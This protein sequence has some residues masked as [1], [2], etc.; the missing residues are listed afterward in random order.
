MTAVLFTH[1]ALPQRTLHHCALQPQTPDPTTARADT[2]HPP[3]DNSD[4]AAAAAAVGPVR[5]LPLY[6]LLPPEGQARVFEATPLGTR[7][8]VVATNVAETSLTI[9]GTPDLPGWFT[10]ILMSYL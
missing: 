9:P 5:V 3:G 4:P 7:L 1:C 10:F 2:A 8:I 6:A